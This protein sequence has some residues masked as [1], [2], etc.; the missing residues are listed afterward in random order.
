[1]V[2]ALLL[3]VG[4]QRLEPRLTRLHK[5]EPAGLRLTPARV[6]EIANRAAW[7]DG[8]VCTNYAQPTTRALSVEP[9]FVK[10]VF[11]YGASDPDP[12][13]LLW[14]V[15]YEPV[16][17]P[18]APGDFFDVFVDDKTARTHIEGGM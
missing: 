11:H 2:F 9:W 5:D 1:M 15:H 13:N 10:L 17:G 14:M 6:V 12:G 7:P 4:C 3:V 18:K 8:M 16:G